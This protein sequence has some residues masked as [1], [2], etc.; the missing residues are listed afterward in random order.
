MRN[1]AAARRSGF[2][3]VTLSNLQAGLEAHRF[4]FTA[5][6]TPPLSM[7]AEDLRALARPLKGLADAVNVTDGA[8]ARA[9]MD[10]LAAAAILLGEGVEPVLQLTGRDRN[11]IALQGALVGAAALGVKNVLF[12]TGDDPKAGDQPEAKPV[13][14]L[15]SVG[16]TST[17]AAI[18]N[19]GVLPHGRTVAGRAEFFIGVSDTLVDPVPGWSPTNLR[20]KIEA[21]AQFVQTQFCMDAGVVRR[22]LA[23]LAD[24]GLAERVH[25]LIGVAPLAS[26]RSARWIRDHLPGSTIPDPLIARLEGARDPRAAGRQACLELI[27]ELAATAGVSGVHIMAPLNEAAIADVLAETR[28]LRA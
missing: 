17:A 26:A 14:D 10:C 8:S 13:F 2:E 3:K 1:C 23:R 27:A 25:F 24:E 4:V 9:H 22:C 15:D 19:S 12:L 16:L 11:R 5:E 7:D 28:R 21:G 6:L 18:R 20:R